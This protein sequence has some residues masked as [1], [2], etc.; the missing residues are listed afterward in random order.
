MEGILCGD[1]GI[2]K[3]T[4]DGGLNWY[5]VNIPLNGVLYSFKNISVLETIH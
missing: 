4:S 3:K 2:V 5:G 1:G